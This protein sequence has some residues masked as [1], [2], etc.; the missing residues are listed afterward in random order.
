MRR[1]L[2]LVRLLRYSAEWSAAAVITSTVSLVEKLFTRRAEAR[3]PPSRRAAASELGRPGGV[4]IEVRG[5]IS[6][7]GGAREGRER[8]EGKG[9]ERAA[10]GEAKV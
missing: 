3:R 9:C 7:D 6:E 2:S 1:F 4:V 5:A 8:G 10:C